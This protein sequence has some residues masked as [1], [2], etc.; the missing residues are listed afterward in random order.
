MSKVWTSRKRII[1]CHALSQLFGAGGELR[2][3]A[4]QPE[5]LLPKKSQIISG[6][7][8]TSVERPLMLYRSPDTASIRHAGPSKDLATG[9]DIL[10]YFTLY[11]G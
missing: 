2:H 11:A 8:D 5:E 4:G 7:R 9:L 6:I 1:T 10:L 3:L